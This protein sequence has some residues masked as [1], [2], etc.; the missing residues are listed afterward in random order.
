MRVNPSIGYPA[1]SIINKFAEKTK[2]VQIALPRPFL[3]FTIS[4]HKVTQKSPLVLHSSACQTQ[5]T[6]SALIFVNNTSR[7]CGPVFPPSDV[8]SWS[9]AYVVPLVRHLTKQGTVYH[10]C[11]L[12]ARYTSSI[13]PWYKVLRPHMRQQARQ[14]MATD[15]TKEV[16]VRRGGRWKQF[17]AKLRL[18]PC[19]RS[20]CHKS[21]YF[22]GKPTAKPDLELSEK[23][24]C[25]CIA[26]K[27]AICGSD[28]RLMKAY[29]IIPEA[30]K[31]LRSTQHGW[32]FSLLCGPAVQRILLGRKLLR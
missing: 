16:E 5:E 12:D 26:Q 14:N 6:L 15:D 11:L 27:S 8:W 29:K 7:P 28:V 3:K 17:L 30:L 18:S 24:H 9:R 4:H 32:W 22:A 10:T 25:S 20:P 2:A 21:I 1:R 19:S 23:I 13:S 31:N